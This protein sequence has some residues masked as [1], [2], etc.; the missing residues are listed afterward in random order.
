MPEIIYLAVALILIV[1]V[2]IVWRASRSNQP[3]AQ[4][5]LLNPPVLDASDFSLTIQ[6]IFNIKGR[7]MVV[8]GRI[9]R[10]SIIVGQRIQIS[11]P[12][13]TQRY[14]TEVAGLEMF[15]QSV[16]SASAGDNVGILFKNLT[17]QIER[18]MIITSPSTF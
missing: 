4:M 3:D 9:E 15:H 14:E 13:G 18:G 8:V 7:G 2:V 6:D 17:D 5:D 12:D 16:N 1:G 11:S 10:G